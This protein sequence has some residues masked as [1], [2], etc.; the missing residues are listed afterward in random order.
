[1]FWMKETLSVPTEYLWRET[2][3][4]KCVHCFSPFLMGW[5]L[6]YK[7]WI[8][9][10]QRKMDESMLSILLLHATLLHGA[11]WMREEEK[12]T[13]AL[14]VR[15]I[16]TIPTWIYPRINRMICNLWSMD[17]FKRYTWIEYRITSLHMDASAPIDPSQHNH[18]FKKGLPMALFP[19]AFT[20]FNVNFP[21]CTHTH[22][23]CCA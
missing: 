19:L 8:C 1:M 2:I 20:H 6:K 21:N 23:A 9:F 11:I 13:T 10:Y 5:D 12:M 15:P 3:F 22:I 14:F 4:L 7:R 16:E 17:K 18:T